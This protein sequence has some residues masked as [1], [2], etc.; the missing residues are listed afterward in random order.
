MER[1]S[2]A[3]G[4]LLRAGLSSDMK[5]VVFSVE[6]GK[7]SCLIGNLFVGIAPPCDVK[8]HCTLAV[9]GSTHSGR[10]ARMLIY[11]DRC[12]FFGDPNDLDRVRT[13]MCLERRCG[14]G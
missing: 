11:P 10:P 9:C 14:H 13:S 5:K 2:L 12:E 3:Y 7:L 1:M 8:E 6:P 4:M